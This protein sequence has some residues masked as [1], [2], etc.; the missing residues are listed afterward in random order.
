MLPHSMFNIGH[1][2]LSHLACSNEFLI[3][4]CHTDGTLRLSRKVHGTIDLVCQVGSIQVHGV[5]AM[6][7]PV[8]IYIECN[9]RNTDGTITI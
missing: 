2:Q 3:K 7:K 8:V 4:K 5:L 9:L 1:Y 6:H